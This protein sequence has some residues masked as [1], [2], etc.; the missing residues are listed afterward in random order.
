MCGGTDDADLWEPKD[1]RS[2]RMGES[3]LKCD[4]VLLANRINC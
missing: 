3:L 1:L 2:W 4:E